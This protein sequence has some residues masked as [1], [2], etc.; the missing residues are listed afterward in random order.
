MISPMPSRWSSWRPH[1]ALIPTV[2]WPHRPVAA[3][4][5]QYRGQDRQNPVRQD[6]RG[7]ARHAVQHEPPGQAGRRRRPVAC[8]GRRA[9][10]WPTWN[11]LLASDAP[12][13]PVNAE[14][15]MQE[16]SRAARSRARWP[17]SCRR[18]RIAAARARRRPDPRRRPGQERTHESTPFPSFFESPLHLAALTLPLLLAACA[19]RR[20]CG[21][22]RCRV[23]APQCRP[24]RGPRRS[25]WVCRASMSPPR[26]TSR[27]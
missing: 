18:T 7:P 22:T 16:L 8:S 2:P 25:C 15:A 4:G 19:C 3:A 6:R 21:T 10:P 27:N 12:S 14:K 23:P 17:T 24:P 20:R 5:Q 26:P 1:P 11:A 9:T 13:L